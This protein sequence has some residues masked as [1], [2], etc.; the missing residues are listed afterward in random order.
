MTVQDLKT[1]PCGKFTNSSSKSF[2]YLTDGSKHPS[3]IES[4]SQM[5]LFKYLCSFL[6][7][8]LFIIEKKKKNKYSNF[9]LSSWNKNLLKL[10]QKLFSSSSFFFGIQ[11]AP[12]NILDILI[13]IHHGP[14]SLL[15]SSLRCK[16]QDILQLSSGLH[17]PSHSDSHI[18][19][20]WLPQC[21]SCGCRHR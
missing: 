16:N 2:L 18:A 8:S 3:R 5:L 15:S 4:R 1:L 20:G 14:Y 6:F 11:K 17:W 13:Q 10:D 12:T 21:Y 7:P 19:F 9:S